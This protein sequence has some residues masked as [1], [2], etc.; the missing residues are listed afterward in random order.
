[1][2]LTRHAEQRLA[3]RQPPDHVLAELLRLAAVRGNRRRAV[4]AW[5]WVAVFDGSRLITVYPEVE[6]LPRRFGSQGPRVEEDE[7]GR[8]R[9]RRYGHKPRQIRRVRDAWCRP[10]E[11]G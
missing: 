10:S 5:G 2:Y 1:M 11:E 6:E 7:E 3:E 8:M 9:C 4:T